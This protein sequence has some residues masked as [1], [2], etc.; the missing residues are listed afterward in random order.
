MASR[1][2][3]RQIAETPSERFERVIKRVMERQRRSDARRT[4]QNRSKAN[5]SAS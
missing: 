2:S 4:K 1:I 3:S 5:V